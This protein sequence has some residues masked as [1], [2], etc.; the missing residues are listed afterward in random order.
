MLLITCVV[1]KKTVG[2]FVGGTYFFFE[3][4]NEKKVGEKK[5]F[6]FRI[7]AKRGETVYYRRG[8]GINILQQ[9]IIFLRYVFLRYVFL[10]YVFLRY[11]FFCVLPFFLCGPM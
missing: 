6:L 2:L 10:R 7:F 11:L 8:Q 1:W 4:V 5:L 3:G 9:I